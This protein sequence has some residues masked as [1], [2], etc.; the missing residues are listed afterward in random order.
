M[1]ASQRT[2]LVAV[3]AALA[4][5][6]SG[7]VVADASY[8]ASFASSATQEGRGGVGHFTGGAGVTP[9]GG[10]QP[11]GGAPPAGAN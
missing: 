4:A 9:P 3:I 7:A 8:H 10:Q 5:I 6:G 1:N 2:G 11:P